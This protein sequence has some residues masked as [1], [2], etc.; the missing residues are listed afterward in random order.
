MISAAEDE[1][2]ECHDYEE[3]RESRFAGGLIPVLVG[4]AE[5]DGGIFAARLRA[6]MPTPL[7][8]IGEHEF[9]IV[10]C[11]QFKTDEVVFV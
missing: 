10:D 9:A 6:G 1:F 5:P 3:R 8:F 7:I 4:F 2:P 11:Q